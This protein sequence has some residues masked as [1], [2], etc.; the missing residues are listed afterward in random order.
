MP[1][2]TAMPDSSIDASDDNNINDGE[3]LEIASPSDFFH[4]RDADDEL[5]PVVQQVPGRE[6]AMRV[7]P[8]TTGD[9]QKFHL[10]DEDALYDDDELFAE[11]VNKFFPDLDFE[12]TAADVRD[13]LIAFGA[14][15]LV[16][17]VKRAGGQDMKDAIDERQIQRMMEMLGDD[18]EF[19]FQKLIEA[20]RQ[21]E[22]EDA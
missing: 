17:M 11:F 22:E 9:Y 4:R 6:E 12:V 18:D 2:D 13:N 19:D 1:D 21:M 14:E 10:D 7:I 16:D 15:P 5:Q 20:G 8:P 3:G